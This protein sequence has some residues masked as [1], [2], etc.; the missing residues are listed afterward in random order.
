MVRPPLLPKLSFGLE[1]QG[2]GTMCNDAV[3]TYLPGRLWRG[4]RCEGLFWELFI[5][6][7]R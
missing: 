1:G 4:E 2:L 3:S 6:E 5:R 7:T